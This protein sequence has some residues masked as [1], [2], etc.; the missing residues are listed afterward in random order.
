MVHFIALSTVL[1]LVL[2]AQV[3]AEE[4]PDAGT[5]PPAQKSGDKVLQLPPVTVITPKA[6]AP[7]KPKAKSGA[8]T[9]PAKPAGPSNQGR[10][11]QA[12][13]GT[14]SHGGIDGVP[15]GL[16]NQL[17]NLNAARENILPKIG[18]N[19]YELNRQAIEA[20]PQG[21]N[22]PL[23]K[24]LLQTPGVYQESA[25]SGNL[26]IRNE[27][28]NLQYRIDGIQLPDGVSGFGEVIETSLIG[29]MSVVTGALPA[30]YGLRTAGLIDIQTRTVAANPSGEISI[31]G[32]SHGTLSSNLQ[33][34]GVSSNTEYFFTGRVLENDLGIE[35]PTASTSAIHDHTQQEKFFSYV[36]TVFPDNARWTLMTG[37]FVGHYQIP[38]NPGQPQQFT[39]PA[40]YN[41]IAFQS[42]NLNEQ[43]LEQNYFGVLAFQQTVGN[44]DYQIAYF[45]RY[46]SVHY[47]PDIL[48]D[49]AFNGIATD[50]TRQSFLNGIQSDAAF[51]VAPDHTLRAGVVVSGEQTYVANSATTFP[52]ILNP[53]GSAT[54]T[55][56]TFVPITDQQSKTGWLAGVY[57]QDEWRITG[58]LTLSTGVRF[59]QM[60]Q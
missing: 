49:L 2:T 30:Q 38:D 56:S 19:S 36:S 13:A 28:A 47:T 14:D 58:K 44:A 33:Y 37:A 31:Y 20:L 9:G 50:V 17:Q 7:A 41:S 60:W 51:R 21:D 52:G 16:S 26:H 55:S 48:G 10:S 24:V 57:V 53:D 4:Q 40:P 12:A 59:D 32:G 6:P 3:C 35:N 34:G 18:V 11:T 42:A 27:H 46:S 15:A 39:L 1:L 23:D 8:K 43:Q 45:T 25:A 29:S 5:S 54:Q 22:A